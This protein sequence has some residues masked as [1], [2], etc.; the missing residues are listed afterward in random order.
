MKIFNN[1]VES[2]NRCCK[3]FSIITI[4]EDGSFISAEIDHLSGY[5]KIEGIRNDVF[6]YRQQTVRHNVFDHSDPLGL[7]ITFVPVFLN[8][9]QVFESK[10]QIII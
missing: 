9:Y 4:P 7:E 1:F 10:L 8:V 5:Y 3:Y 6:Y 2:L